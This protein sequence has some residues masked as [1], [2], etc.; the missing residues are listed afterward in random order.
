MDIA[1]GMIESV[2]GFE[3]ESGL[4]LGVFEGMVWIHVQ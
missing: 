2:A 4:V 3:I 1:V